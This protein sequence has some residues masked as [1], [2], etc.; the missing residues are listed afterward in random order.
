[1]ATTYQLYRPRSVAPNAAA[2]FGVCDLVGTYSSQAN[3][4]A[5]PS[6]AGDLIVPPGYDWSM[7]AYRPALTNAALVT[8]VPQYVATGGGGG[9]VANYLGPTL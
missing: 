7:T 9:T 8:G 5:A 6:V 4:M 1:L 2:G 3:A